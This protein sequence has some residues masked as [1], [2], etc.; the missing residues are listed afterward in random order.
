[1]ALKV[2]LHATPGL[3]FTS[4]ALEKLGTGCRQHSTC[5]GEAFPHF[6]GLKLSKQLE[7]EVVCHAGHMVKG[8]QVVVTGSPACV[9]AGLWGDGDGEHNL[10]WRLWEGGL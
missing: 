5:E 1:M 8:Q 6:I 10:V 7:E 2:C 4:K 9:A 3:V